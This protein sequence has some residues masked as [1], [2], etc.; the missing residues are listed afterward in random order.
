MA[1]YEEITLL[2]SILA[3]VGGT[4]VEVGEYERIQLLQG[5]SDALSTSQARSRFIG[6]LLQLT[7]DT[8]LLWLPASTDTTTSTDQSLT[9]RTV[10][11]DATIA[12]RL[13]ALGLGQKVSF[14]GSSQFGSTP[15]TA[16]LSFGNASAD[17][18]MSVIVLA[19]VTDTAATRVLV[20]KWDTASTLREWRFRLNG[21]DALLFELYDESVDKT[22]LRTS[23]GAATMGSWCLYG[24]TY[25]AATGGATAGNDITLYENGLVKASTATNDASYVAMEDTTAQGMIGADGNSSSAQFFMSG[26]MA[27]VIVCQKSLS[28]SDH[29]AIR[30]LCEGYFGFLG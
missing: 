24:A 12:A 14:N 2:K 7:G 8:R 22:P 28:A 4:E 25:T 9:G 26:A 21:S 10:T 1:D 17:S 13:S 16:N 29:C 6:Q 18:A 30:K 15:D 27:L 11:Y 3:S 20:G 23:T 19:N 5:I